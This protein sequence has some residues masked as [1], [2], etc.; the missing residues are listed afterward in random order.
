[1]RRYI[2]GYGLTESCSGD[3]L[4]EAGR[5]IEKIGSTGRALPHVEVEIRDDAGAGAAAEHAGRDLPARAAHHQGLLE[6]SG[7][8]RGQASS[9]TGS[10]P[11]TSV[12]WMRMA[13]CS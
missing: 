11:A 8:D 4:M 12:T 1:M 7:K 6:G 13:F 9:A 3:T 10:A 5:E 2:D